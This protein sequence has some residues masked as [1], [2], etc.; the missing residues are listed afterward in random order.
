MGRGY[1][2]VSLASANRYTIGV[3]LSEVAVEAAASAIAAL[4]PEIRPDPAHYELRAMSFFDLDEEYK[5]DFVYDYTFL[6][7]LNPAVRRDWAKKMAAIIKEGGELLTIIF[8]IREKESEV[9]PFR[10][11]LD[12]YKELLEPAGFENFQLVR[13]KSPLKMLLLLYPLFRNLSQF[14]LYMFRKF[15]PQSFA[16]K[17]EMGRQIQGTS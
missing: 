13:L 11:T 7:A 6:C 2:V 15:Y 9:P 8:P 1:D 17:E 3:D 10:V 5:F 4:P 14:I 16:M 12:L